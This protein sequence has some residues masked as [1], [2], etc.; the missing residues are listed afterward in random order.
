M[1]TPPATAGPAPQAQPG[2]ARTNQG[3]KLKWFLPVGAGISVIALVIAILAAGT[4]PNPP[5]SQM[6]W[7]IMTVVFVTFC[8]R[9]AYKLQRNL[10]RGSKLESKRANEILHN[11]RVL[12]GLVSVAAMAV[13]VF[14]GSVY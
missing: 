1:T 11:Q 13:G 6:G 5:I 8:A 2:A 3:L 14:L 7:A 12:L 9:H 10:V 4:R